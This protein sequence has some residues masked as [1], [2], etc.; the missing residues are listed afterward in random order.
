VPFPGLNGR[1]VL[2]TGAGGFIGRHVVLRLS[3]NSDATL[4]LLIRGSAGDLLEATRGRS[5]LVR[6]DRPTTLA[7]SVC[8]PASTLSSIVPQ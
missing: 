7:L 4:R 5:E 2:V 3:E 6:G 8:V 1:R